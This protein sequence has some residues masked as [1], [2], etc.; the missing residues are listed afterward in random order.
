M[1]NL[2]PNRSAALARLSS[3]VPNADSAY[4]RTRNYDLPSHPHVSM[5]SPYVRHRILTEH[6]ILQAVLGR[7]SL[8][9]AEKF[10]QEVYWRTYWKGWLELRPALWSDYQRDVKDA[11]NQV[12]TQSGLRARWEAACKGETGIACFDHWARELAQTGYLHNHARMW[13]ASIWCFTLELPW[14]LGADFFL[15]HLL[16]GDPA[17]NTL[18]WRWVAGIQTQGKT[19]LARPDNIAKYTEFRFTPKGLASHAAPVGQAN[20]PLERQLP[21]SDTLPS[22]G[23]LGLLV[24]EDDL[25]PGWISCQMQPAA[26]A[27]IQTTRTRSP[28]EVSDVVVDW[29]R[30]AMEDAVAR[31]DQ[32]VRWTQSVEDITHWAQAQ[33]LNHVV[34]SYLPTGP[35][36]DALS[37]LKDKLAAAGIGL[38]QP[39]RS[40]DSAAWPHA[41]AGFFKFKTQIPKLVQ[42]L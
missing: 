6:E 7:Y 34:T 8:S 32:D 31:I 37:G 28:L 13:F 1:I 3:F 36:Q 24:T 11:L 39:R 18:S 38:I 14:Q 10:V 21:I 42:Q 29:V 20:H 9:S 33:N 41:T 35:T 2:A 17:S 15:R 40:Y 16:D 22:K 4:A 19:Y 27:A 30:S 25:S 5:L 23:T 12:Q 26:V